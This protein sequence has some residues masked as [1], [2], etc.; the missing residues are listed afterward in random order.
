[1]PEK[2]LNPNELRPVKRLTPTPAL[3]VPLQDYSNAY[4]EYYRPEYVQEYNRAANQSGLEQLVYGA[5]SRTLSIIPKVGSGFASVGAALFAD[6][7]QDIWDNPMVEFFNGLDESLKNNLPVYTSMKNAES[8]LWG[9]MGTSSFWANDGFDG[10]AFAASAF[11]PGGL[12]GKGLGAGAKALSTSQLA[13]G[14]G[15]SLKGIEVGAKA[16]NLALSTAYNTVAEAAVEAYQTQQEVQAIIQER[17]E[18]EGMQPEEATKIAK[19]KASEAAARTFR[20][21]SAVL[22]VPNLVQNMFFH[23]GLNDMQKTVRSAVRAGGGKASAELAK[24]DSIWKA[25]GGGVLSEGIWEEN[26]QTSIQQYERM[27][28]KSGNY[29]L[30]YTTEVGTNMGKNVL[31]FAK[32]LVGMDSTPDEVEGAVSIFLGGLIGAG[33]GAYGTAREN[34]QRKNIIESEE[35]RYAKLFDESAP[36]ALGIMTDNVAS[37]FKVKGKRNIKQG[38]KDVEIRDFDLDAN[39]NAIEDPEAILKLTLN[40]LKNKHLWDAEMLA[41]YRND[42]ALKELNKHEA[43]GS[44]VYALLSAGYELEEVNHLLDNLKQVGDSEAKQLGV[45]TMLA[46]NVS[47]AKEYAKEL[48][49]I[50]S[51]KGS[52][53]VDLSNPAEAKF[54]DWST[55]VEFYL[56]LKSKALNT[57]ISQATT[58]QGRNTII[59]LQEDTNE[60]LRQLREETSAIKKEYMKTIFDPALKY[61]EASK[62]E[63]KKDRTV[64]EENKLRE[65]RYLFFEDQHINGEW[66]MT[67]G[68][69]EL[70]SGAELSSKAKTRPGSKDRMNKEVGATA[71][72]ISRIEETLVQDSPDYIG[73]ARDFDNVTIREGINKDRVDRALV[74]TAKGIDAE[75]AS[76]QQNVSSSLELGAATEALAS[77]D[78]LFEE[79]LTVNEV[80]MEAFSDSK[81]SEAEVATKAAEAVEA[82]AGLGI[83]VQA[84]TPYNADFVTANADALNQAAQDIDNSLSQVIARSQELANAKARL[85]GAAV[86]QRVN[87]QLEDYNNATNKEE[88][89][90]RDYYETNIGNPAQG[91]IDAFNKDP[92]NFDNDRVF[93]LVAEDLQDTIEAY[94]KREDD[95]V[96]DGV[97]EDA[98]KKLAFLEEVIWKKI[99]DNLSKRAEAHRDTNNRLVLSMLQALGL[100]GKNNARLKTLLESILSKDKV[101]KLLEDV[102]RDQE[103]L[104]FDA[105][106]LIITTAYAKANADEKKNIEEALSEFKSATITNFVEGLPG[107]FQKSKKSILK[108]F[109]NQTAYL[110][111][112]MLVTYYEGKQVPDIINKY[113][114]DQ[115]LEFLARRAEHSKELSK[116]DQTFIK[117]LKK[118]SDTVNAINLASKWF[119]IG[120]IDYGKLVELKKGIDEKFSPSLQ[121]NIALTQAMQFLLTPAGVDNFENWLL[122]RGI[123]GAGKTFLMGPTLISLFNQSMSKVAKVYAFSKNPRTTANINKA[124]NAKTNN[125]SLN[126]LLAMTD[127]EIAAHDFILIDEVYTFTNT[128][129]ALISARL[130]EVKNT[131]NKIVKVIALGDPSQVTAEKESVLM[132]GLKTQ[133]TVPLTTSYRTNVSAIGAF[134][135]AFQLNASEVNQPRAQA[136]KTLDEVIASP[137]DSFG[138]IAGSREDLE[139]VLRQ[140]STR[141]RVLIVS[142]PAAKQ[143]LSYSGV[144]I[145]TVEEAQGLQWDE[146]YTYLDPQDLG[147]TAFEV[148]KNLYTAYSR[149]QNLLFIAGSD[150]IN[151]SPNRT[152]DNTIETAQNELEQAR[153]MYREN[154]KLSDVATKILN[155]TAVFTTEE[156]TEEEVTSEDGPAVESNTVIGPNYVEAPEQELPKK[157]LPESPSSGTHKL[158]FPTNRMLRSDH[159]AV[160]SLAQIVK[161]DKDNYYVLAPSVIEPGSFVV[162]AMLGDEDFNG[163]AGDYFSAISKSNKPVISE[164]SVSKGSPMPFPAIAKFSLGHIVL[165][166][167]QTFKTLTVDTTGENYFNDNINLAPGAN[168]VIEDAIIRFYNS[169]YGPEANGVVT[170]QT[171]APDKR[172]VTKDKQGNFKVNWKAVGNNARMEIMTRKL[173]RNDPSLTED[174]TVEYGLP[175]LIITPTIASKSGKETNAK[176]ILIKFQPKK[177]N[178][179]SEKYKEIKSFLDAAKTVEELTNL[180]LGVKDTVDRHGE[181]AS[182]FA[183]FVRGFAKANLVVDYEKSAY[184]ENKNRYFVK[185]R[186]DLV[187][188]EADNPA[189][190][191]RLNQALSAIALQIWGVKYATEFFSGEDEAWTYIEENGVKSTANSDEYIVEGKRVVN[192]TPTNNGKFVIQVSQDATDDVTTVF[193]HH[194]IWEGEGPAQVALNSLAQANLTVGSYGNQ[195]R[196]VKYRNQDNKDVKFT[197]AQSILEA[198][199]P[200]TDF[201]MM[202]KDSRITDLLEAAGYEI[203]ETIAFGHLINRLAKGVQILEPDNPHPK[204]T[205]ESLVDMYT[206][207]P[208]DTTMLE[209]IVGDAAFDEKG[210]HNVGNPPLRTPLR[211]HTA[212]KNGVNDLGADLSNS[213]SRQ[214]LTTNLRHNFTGVVKTSLTIGLPVTA[215]APQDPQEPKVTKTSLKKVLGAKF[216]TGIDVLDRLVNLFLSLPDIAIFNYPKGVPERMADGTII[217]HSNVMAAGQLDDGTWAI[218]VSTDLSNINKNNTQLSGVLHEALHVVTKGAL[219]KGLS[220]LR[221]KKDTPEAIFYK[222]FSTIKKRFDSAVKSKINSATGEKYKLNEVYAATPSKLDI[223]EFAANLSNPKF[224]ALAKDVNLLPKGTRRSILRELVEAIIDFFG[225][226]IGLNPNVYDAAMAVLEDFIALPSNEQVI[227]PTVTVTKEDVSKTVSELKQSVI[228]E[229]TQALNTSDEFLFDSN[230]EFIKSTGVIKSDLLPNYGDGFTLAFSDSF[231]KLPEHE[232]LQIL[233]TVTSGL[234]NLS[235]AYYNLPADVVSMSPGAI[236]STKGTFNMVDRVIKNM[237]LNPKVVSLLRSIALKERVTPGL[238]LRLAESYDDISQLRDIFYDEIFSKKDKTELLIATNSRGHDLAA[239]RIFNNPNPTEAEKV[240]IDDINTA[241]NVLVENKWT[242][243]ESINNQLED[244]AVERYRLAKQY[245]LDRLR[246]NLNK[247]TVNVDDFD[248]EAPVNLI[249]TRAEI[250]EEIRK[251]V[252]ANPLINDLAKKLAAANAEAES[253]KDDKNRL[254]DYND[255]VFRV[256]PNLEDQLVGIVSLK[257]RNARTGKNILDEVLKDIYPKYELQD[258]EDLELAL[259]IQELAD[260]DYVSKDR[261]DDEIQDTANISE[262]IKQYNKSYE[263]TLSESLKD[264]LSHIRIGDKNISNSLAYIKTIQLAVNL[265]WS[266]GVEGPAGI[267]AQLSSAL[268]ETSALSELDRV[269]ITGLRDVFVKSTSN[270]YL[271]GVILDDT[272]GIVSSKAD[273]GII[274]YS[275]YTLGSSEFIGKSYTYPELENI[276]RDVSLVELS[277]RFVSTNKLYNWLKARRPNMTI[278]QFNRMF[279]KAEAINMA[280]GIMNTMGSMKETDL[281]LATRTL[282][283]GNQFRFIKSKASG[284]SF[285]IRDGI[286]QMIADLHDAGELIKFKSKFKNAV[287]GDKTIAQLEASNKK[288]DREKFIK[289]FF[290]RLG[291]KQEGFN[292]TIKNKDIVELINAIN[293]FL[294]A[295]KLVTPLDENSE[296]DNV[297]DDVEQ[298]RTVEFADWVDNNVG[299]YI[300]RFSELLAKSDLLYR[301]PSVRDSKGN[302]FY[303]FHE[304]SWAYDVFLNLIDI[305]K[306]NP[307]FK[308]ATGSNNT[309]KV[310]SYLKAKLYNH[311]IFVRGNVSSKIYGIGEYEA[312]R[313][314]DIGSV[315]PYLRENQ[316]YFYHRKFIQGFLDGLRQYN[317]ESY[318]QFTYPPSDKPK[319]PM[320]RIGLL[321]DGKEG[322]KID[323]AIEQALTQILEK[324]NVLLDITNYNQSHDKDLFRNFM[325]GKEAIKES[326]L[327]FTAENIPA[328]AKVAKQLMETKASSIL[329]TLLSEGI[330]L[331][332]D[333]STYGYMRKLKDK[334]NPKFI[335]PTEKFADDQG[336]KD[337][338]FKNRENKEYSVDKAEILPL[339]DLFF[340]NNYLNSYFLNQIVTGDYAAYKKDSSD[341]VK[342]YAGVFGPRVK[343]LVDAKIG[344]REKFKVLVLADTVE[345]T[346]KSD[347]E[348]Q[349]MKELDPLRAARTTRQRLINLLFNGVEPTGQDSENFE[350][351]MKQFSKSFESTDAQGFILPSRARELH[352]G[353]EISW[354]L[355]HVHKPLYFGNKLHSV[356]GYSTAIPVYLKYSAVELTEELV[357]RFPA[358]R[359]LRDNA[360]RLGIDEIIFNSGVKEG[361][362]IVRN[363]AGEALERSIQFQEF[364]K[365]DEEQLRNI[366]TKWLSPPVMEL[367][368]V[369]YGLQHNPQADPNKGVSLFTQLLYFLNV[370]P[371][372]LE[373]G[374]FATTQDAAMQSYELLAEL[375]KTGREDFEAKVQNPADLK[376]FLLKKFDGPGAERALAL[377]EE[378]ISINHPL[379]EKRAVLSIASGMEKA[380][381][382]TKFAGGKLVLQTAE[383][384]D[385]YQDPRLFK[386]LD[387][388]KARDLQYRMEEIEGKKMLVAEVIVPRDI[389]TKEQIQ[390]ISNGESI[391]LLPDALGFRIP[392]TELHSAVPLRVVGVY[393]AKLTNV[394]IAPKELVAIHGSDFDVD[395]LFVVTKELFKT[396]DNL[397]VNADFVTH[398]MSSLRLLFDK[399]KLIEDTSTSEVSLKIRNFK[400]KVKELSGLLTEAE[401]ET[402][403]ITDAQQAELEEEFQRF[404]STPQEMAGSNQKVI[405]NKSKTYDEAQAR[406]AWGATKGLYYTNLTGEP[407]WVSNNSLY[408]KAEAT[409]RVIADFVE[410]NPEL[411]IIGK[412]L[413]EVQIGLNLTLQTRNAKIM[414][415]ADTPIG[416]K[417]TTGGKY[418]INNEFLEDIAEELE[419]LELIKATM[420]SELKPILGS[421]VAN[422]ISRLNKLKESYLKNRIIDIMLAVISD[423]GNKYRMTAPISFESVTSAIK[424][425]NENLIPTTTY[426]LSDVDDEYK[427]YS[428]LTA[429]VVLT[430]AFANA[431]KSFG[432]YARAGASK[433]VQ[434]AYDYYGELVRMR[435]LL[436]SIKSFTD[437]EFA[438]KD[439][440]K[441]LSEV[442]VDSNPFT[443]LT[444]DDYKD[445]KTLVEDVDGADVAKWLKLVERLIEHSRAKVISFNRSKFKKVN[446]SPLLNRRYKFNLNIDGESKPFDRLAIVDARGEYTVTQVYDALTNEAIDNLKVGDLVKARINQNTGSVVI[447]LVAVGVP[448]DII[449]KLLY[450]PIFAGLVTGKVNNVE[451]WLNELTSQDK[452]GPAM[453]LASSFT[454]SDAELNMMLKDKY[455]KLQGQPIDAIES[456]LGANEWAIQ[457]KALDLFAKGYKIGEDMRNM[458]NF[459]NILRKHDVFIEDIM[460]LDDNLANNIGNPEMVGDDLVLATNLDHSFVI[461]NLFESA[462]HIREAYKTHLSTIDIISKSLKIH[463]PEVQQFA[464]KVYAEL[465]TISSRNDQGEKDSKQEKLANIRRSLSFYLLSHIASGDVK[466]NPEVIT[467][468]EDKEKFTLSKLRTFSNKVANTVTKLRDLRGAKDNDFIR[469]LVPVRDWKGSSYLTFKSGVNLSPEDIQE[470]SLGFKALNKYH[471]NEDGTISTIT[472][473][474]NSVSNIQKDLLNYAIL[475]YGLQ[476]SSSN[477]SNYVAPKMFKS[478]D[479]RYN[480]ALDQL[481]NT[482]NSISR[483]HFMLSHI[484]QNASALSYIPFENIVPTVPG[485][486]QT[487]RKAVYSGKTT[488]EKLSGLEEEKVTIYY[489]LAVTT[490]NTDGE[491][492]FKPA[493]YIRRGFGKKIVVFKLV[494]AADDMYYYQKV[495]R[496]ADAFHTPFLGSYNSNEMFTAVS[497][498]IEYH[499]QTK[500][501]NT[502]NTYSHLSREIQKGD[503]IY[504]YPSYNFDRSERQQVE[505]VSITPGNPN[506]KIPGYKIKY[507]PIE[508]NPA[509]NQLLKIPGEDQLDLIGKLILI[510]QSS[511]DDKIILEKLNK[512]VSHNNATQQEFNELLNLLYSSKINIDA[513]GIIE[514]LKNLYNSQFTSITTIK[515]IDKMLADGQVKQICKK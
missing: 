302:K 203:D 316:Y 259:E 243:F 54:N 307:V 116:A 483:A 38:D 120:S 93:K 125:N 58:E 510:A 57:L 166:D 171:N 433:E 380:T 479:E 329:D 332:F 475:N 76:V 505:V 140:P 410:D 233:Q 325:I 192:V 111:Q 339:F 188:E 378:G 9:K 387:N 344:M 227:T 407:K 349:Q 20:A 298:N 129:I 138:V 435:K 285:N 280:R 459:L 91:F 31:G 276:S 42:P 161:T 361:M 225:K 467:V 70:P 44:Y 471:L 399:L 195:F 164:S 489:D 71:I 214:V 55:K 41:A 90:K 350:K 128:E 370:Y 362:P 512:I 143:G 106:N 103:I 239:E 178:K 442:F 393:S 222:R 153:E 112:F 416:Y 337:E 139:K 481:I 443:D 417:K 60:Q 109:G 394:I 216:V 449:V 434:K 132:Q 261:I 328:I 450:Q 263:N 319:H 283:E 84:D 271:D 173:Q 115:D 26:A 234:T 260:A 6:N 83:Q 30:D 473:P 217:F 429:G 213:A 77:S 2:I 303:K 317:T 437:I 440:K 124:L 463:S 496:L 366:S 187:L 494:E 219:L 3:N 50:S 130:G 135:K 32:G 447:G 175:Y 345:E 402:I 36:A 320:L 96:P 413:T 206:A 374:N 290:S 119:E 94:T 363:E 284:V 331:T 501:A 335:L 353:F 254:R 79:G 281:F 422:S 384:I 141:S 200:Y 336:N 23:G 391:Y 321:S 279:T 300:T 22:A 232:Q 270:S 88:F 48:S 392:S 444:K 52:A 455:H 318:F 241:L 426:D 431:S 102:F 313:N 258:E 457:L 272:I 311:N 184:D 355:G 491:S 396:G 182:A 122:V 514:Y 14:L 428:S 137:K 179:S 465:P 386:D 418:A 25:I 474:G 154:L 18:R 351:L 289:E 348:F 432:Y 12:I 423:E 500:D 377:L 10:I 152:M 356:D 338:S 499:Y 406:A 8:G 408:G 223:L 401:S 193:K 485:D 126:D 352:R 212:G 177:F 75:L 198:G 176:R 237:K 412:E 118:A 240:I 497:P 495:G 373:T 358:L 265:D 145:V 66:A 262:H 403:T 247:D 476:F 424:T 142:N 110:V 221:G 359:K 35:K 304:S 376:K 452:Y 389:L 46:N 17:L 205:A 28:A 360:E 72:A 89:L 34:R 388:S 7:L 21:N 411:Q 157:V 63:A 11:V 515:D 314:E 451:R 158:S 322:N 51:K 305:N 375:I 277:S 282:N 310:P 40:Q 147:N 453:T 427:A 354:G 78:W 472:N 189:D 236:V 446:T 441:L 264:Y 99:Q 306:N 113:I 312:A 24:T 334:L 117:D 149:A 59:K 191:E 323:G 98:K 492:K 367:D 155:G 395:A 324:K 62:L 400:R 383:G 256:I 253:L 341:I 172:W 133:F 170:K 47:L 371:T 357:E 97:L 372:I 114:H 160:N 183:E 327:E 326:G 508:I 297:V 238:M 484:M 211:I 397:I 245:V 69:R 144:D 487:K 202:Y 127:A 409:Q 458:S 27:A 369:N 169:Y 80:L 156:L 151:S 104:S 1:M 159:V 268:Q 266:Q 486:K 255:L 343:G 148:N 498:S 226:L 330:N 65:L 37:T 464:E 250:I 292:I 4:D 456:T 274:T 462:P 477:Y 215:E 174:L 308:G 168:D 87:K 235:Y 252:K 197:R 162:V 502:V 86:S 107:E 299:T 95:N 194:K 445:Y 246:E 163:P 108:N 56:G 146:V 82:L 134:N 190:T 296:L 73:I 504:I 16:S 333:K 295:T 419:K 53:K 218:F 415:R 131:V 342:R 229:F 420:Q 201:E 482:P 29:D 309:R 439:L 490:A 43:L 511:S 315:T 506:S 207:A 480:S 287:V 381:V 478:T 421:A 267:I 61:A 425:I 257:E 181:P 228:A 196:K 39:G 273:N 390:S 123:G 224:V 220:D 165:K 368:N 513:H 469:N 461:P 231:N 503:L 92:E 286:R 186:D 15:L 45:D 230:L 269:I 68:S 85:E 150:T 364:V 19:G 251:S 454:L 365:L 448:M 294:D 288:G 436:S 438:E 136:N 347:E 204:L 64:D 49:E 493:E 293:G 81:L 460:Q 209:Q 100:S 430:G 248:P 5:A 121:Q 398:Y 67:G 405:R 278:A 301:N 185:L 101:E 291:L 74:D 488:I 244:R 385:L 468:G 275:A 404:V 33:M 13:K 105:L 466:V 379:L 249:R 167:Y 210:E 346:A 382:K 509:E 414:G 242:A 507:K 208:V 180:K 340:K 470:F 199:K